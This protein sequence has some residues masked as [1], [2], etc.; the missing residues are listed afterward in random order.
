MSQEAKHLTP[1]LVLMA[2]TG[3]LLDNSLDAIR[4]TV[5]TRREVLAKNKAGSMLPG[6]RFYIKDIT[7][8]KWDGL[9]VTYLGREGRVWLKCRLSKE[10]TM[11]LMNCDEYLWEHFNIVKLRESHVG[12][13]TRHQVSEGGL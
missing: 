8:A 3:G 9:E 6:D 13:F 12:T 4:E 11:R 2:I 5:R 7:P 1:E 10:D